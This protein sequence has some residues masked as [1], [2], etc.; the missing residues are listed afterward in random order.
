MGLGLKIR[1]GPLPPVPFK[2]RL[3]TCPWQ[4]RSHIISIPKFSVT[5]VRVAGLKVMPTTQEPPAGRLWEGSSVTG[6][7]AGMPLGGA[8]AEDGVQSIV[9][10]EGRKKS[11]NIAGRQP[12]QL[13]IFTSCSAP[14]V[15]VSGVAGNTNGFGEK[16][17]LGRP[18]AGTPAVVPARFTV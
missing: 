17:R 15:V 10:C 16:V 7:H 1:T 9:K 13:V 14:M 5:G 4:G 8:R 12:A 6:L 2:D 18:A 11:E 3:K